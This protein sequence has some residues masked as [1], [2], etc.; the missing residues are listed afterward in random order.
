[1]KQNTVVYFSFVVLF[2]TAF[3]LCEG[4]IPLGDFRPRFIFI[5]AALFLSPSLFF[6]KGV[7]ALIVYYAFF[8]LSRF[9]NNDE[10]ETTG[11]LAN[12]MEY[13]IPMVVLTNI[14]HSPDKDAL[15]KKMAKFSLAIIVITACLTL[16]TLLFVDSNAVR[17]VVGRIAA[18]E[19]VLDL[20]RMGVADYATA[21]M[22]MVMP[23]IGVFIYRKIASTH[24]KRILL[25]LIA[26]FF[27]F[28]LKSQITTPFLISIVLSGIA[29]F[30]KGDNVK[31]VFVALTIILIVF[32]L[33]ED[34]I[35]ALIG[36]VSSGSSEVFERVNDLSVYSD[37]GD[38][39]DGDL[40]GRMYYYGLTLN[41]IISDPLFGTS[42]K[43]I[44]GHAFFLDR[45]ALS[46]IIGIIPYVI[47]LVTQFK[48]SLSFVP[49][50]MK[51]CYQICM[52]GFIL[53]GFVKNMAG[54]GYWLFMFLYIPCILYWADSLI[55]KRMEHVDTSL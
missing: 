48:V 4:W 45:I 21:T 36:F 33:F 6:S 2:L 42:Y 25:V 47:M 14:M 55:E 22:M 19:S 26:L 1:M 49:E 52:L 18:G 44:G 41:G 32:L 5:I 54:F 38:L 35:F 39:G 9:I 7:V 40:A 28:L 11:L 43:N 24:Y 17:S 16:F 15:A 8:L 3:T 10:V 31:A 29:I 13:A 46:G 23:A 34:A 20:Y 53:L 12:I 51:V 27:L 50:R 30:V 37:T